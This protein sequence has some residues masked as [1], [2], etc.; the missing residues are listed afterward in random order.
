MLLFA[1]ASMLG[2]MAWHL[3]L[4]SGRTFLFMKDFLDKIQFKDAIFIPLVGLMFG[5]ILSSVTTFF[6][7]S[8]VIQN[9]SA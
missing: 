7:Y 8:N 6:A 4:H 5:N 9:M 2:K 1:N 3:F